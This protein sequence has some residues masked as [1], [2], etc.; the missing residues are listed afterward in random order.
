MEEHQDIM[1]DML[2]FCDELVDDIVFYNTTHNFML[3]DDVDYII[4]R[5]NQFEFA[6]NEYGLICDE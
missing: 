2:E 4:D 1:V 6:L 5:Y 3:D